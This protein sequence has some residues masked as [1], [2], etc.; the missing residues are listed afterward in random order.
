MY[1][2]LKLKPISNNKINTK[3]LDKQMIDQALKETILEFPFSTFPY[4]N[5]GNSK[6]CQ[7]QKEGNCIALSM[8]LKNKLQKKNIKSFLVPAG[9]PKKYSHPKYIDIS[10]CA[11]AII[12][13]LYNIFL[14]DPAFYYNESV[15]LNFLNKLTS[16]C[17][18]T[19][20]YSNSVDFNK[21]N[22]KFNENSL[23]L[24]SFQII[25]PKTFFINAYDKTDIS[26]NWNY[27][28]TELINPD[29]AISNFYINIKNLPFITILDEKY[30]LAFY[31]KFLDKFNIYIKSYNNSLY[32]GHKN[33]IPSYLNN[34]LSSYLGKDWKDSSYLSPNIRDFPYIIKDRSKRSKK[35]KKSKKKN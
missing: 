6:T 25:P 16:T 33:N 32:N 29:E 12:D 35:S 15:N 30:K 19:N 22:L 11:L 14:C 10:H 2:K 31:L 3:K 8:Y 9:I 21:F 4:I 23:T 34:I 13:N 26:D 5:G 18:Y 17:P 1:H 27:Y 28:L 20:I 7:R 24:N